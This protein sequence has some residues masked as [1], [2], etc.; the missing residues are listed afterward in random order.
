MT[1]KLQ[2]FASISILVA[3][4][5]SAQVDA[6][7]Q[8]LQGVYFG[9]GVNYSS[10]NL[11][12]NSWGLGISDLYT[13]SVFTSRGIADGNAAPFKNNALIFS[14]EIQVGFFKNINPITYWGVKFTYQYLNSTATN[15]DLYLPQTGVLATANPPG[16]SAMFGYAIADSVETTI[17]HDLKLLFSIGQ[18][19]CNQYLY[20]GVGPTLINLKS[21]NYNSIGYAI[22]DGVP[23]NVTGLV[24]YG[25]PNIWAWGGAAQIGMNYFIN[26][27]WFIDSSYTYSM[28]G[29][30]TSP[31][32]Q[33]FANTSIIAGNTIFT[34]GILATEDTFKR[35][36]SQTINISI[37]K[38]FA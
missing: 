33:T 20:M 13:N 30:K 32:E 7:P 8:D 29:S 6:S 4:A 28:T 22:V 14:P 11:T 38:Y 16:T 25:S 18:T 31:H 26:P 34:T 5:F 23:L 19:I 35:V 1:V 9:L 10:L 37:N 2:H 17:N 36:T 24:N 27:C 21:K 15:R 12:Q 3:Y